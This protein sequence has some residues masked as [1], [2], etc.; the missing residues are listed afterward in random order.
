M[1]SPNKP[2]GITTT[3]PIEVLLAAGYTPVD[4]NNI[5]ISDENPERLVRLAER[6]GF[7]LNT[8]AWIKGIYS[9]C[10][11][12]KIDTVL[13]VTTGD[14]SNTTMLMEVLKLRGIKT[15]PFA[16]PD[17]PN[18][19]KMQIAL[20][21]L[22][23]RLETTVAEAEVVRQQ[24]K[25][26]RDAVHELD[27]LTWHD[28]RVSGMENHYWL[29][30][31]SDFNRD[32]D[33]YRADVQKLVA[34][35]KQRKPYPDGELRLAFVGVPSVYGKDLYPFLEQNG[36]RVV[37]NEIQRQFAMPAPGKSLA[38]QY[39]NYTY[40]YSIEGRILDIKSEVERRHIDGVIHYVQA[41]CHRAIGDIVFRKRLPVPIL[42]IEGNTD[43]ALTQHL[44]TRLEAFIDMLGQMK[45]QKALR[46]GRDC[47]PNKN[48]E[49]KTWQ[50]E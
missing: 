45:Q 44:K 14:C 20:E 13:C 49:A 29:V 7:P 6:A 21:S 24:L 32:T 5:F 22:A 26:C 11:E 10:L 40:P 33:K 17:A 2:I 42:T 3:V 43:F 12:Q 9:V 27:R 8:C 15:I 31:S 28:N 25:P 50:P 38:E 4:L 36:A 23:G 41:F 19:D 35:A 30:S 39:T 34:E 1:R 16:Y 37:Y 48:Q 47:P 46:G 18:I